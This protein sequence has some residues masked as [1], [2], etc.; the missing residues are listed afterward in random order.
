MQEVVD[1]PYRVG[2]LLKTGMMLVAKPFLW[3]FI[4]CTS[5]CLAQVWLFVSL[6]L[7]HFQ[8][9]QVDPFS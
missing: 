2:L 1:V 3:S 7:E 4:L 6:D 9:I 8:S 5:I